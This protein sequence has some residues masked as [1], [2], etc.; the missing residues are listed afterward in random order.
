MRTLLLLAF[1]LIQTVA[2]TQTLS[3]GDQKELDY[4]TLLT[5]VPAMTVYDQYGKKYSL[6]DYI[7]AN[8]LHDN[9]PTL[10]V[11]WGSVKS[12]I[13][14]IYELDEAG[15]GDRYN[16][17]FIYLSWGK[18]T[19]LVRDFNE[20]L[21]AAKKPTQ[22]NKFLLVA[23]TSDEILAKLYANGFPFYYYADAK[24]NIICRTG[25]IDAAITKN[26]LD[27]ISTGEIKR[28]KL[29][30]TKEGTL[31]SPQ[32]KEAYYWV[33]YLVKDNRVQQTTG[34]KNK[35]LEN[36]SYIRKNNNYLYDGLAELV[37]ES[38]QT[39]LT[40]QFKEGVPITTVKMWHEDGK[41]RGTY[42]V[43]GKAKL[44]DKEGSLT[45]EGPMENGLGN[46]LFVSYS[47]G[48][49]TSEK[50]Y[51]QGVLYGLQKLF[52]G[53]EVNEYF[54]SAE[55]EMRGY[56]Q[57]DLQLVSSNGL[58]GYID[59][60]G[61]PVIK[62]QY[63]AGESFNKGTALVEKNGVKFYIDR[64]GKKLTEKEAKAIQQ[65]GKP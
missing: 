34:I 7:S 54:E 6:S 9:K 37:S 60:N 63:T 25:A 4:Q 17:V 52:K 50:N 65:S 21:N 41:I 36:I 5:R 38:G 33:Q 59:R 27:G 61:Y 64:K 12:Y 43:N 56:F 19:E 16:I 18:E 42:P 13:K 48:T 55:Y 62:L 1:L 24:F 8:K 58:Y 45:L 46:G 44:F 49:K 28:G 26:I 32:H 10:L 14:K 11:T 53:D 2:F 30:F 23:A 22:W 31:V 57:E 51:K 29:W 40:G 3:F 15:L 47:K 20:Q 39:L 35:T